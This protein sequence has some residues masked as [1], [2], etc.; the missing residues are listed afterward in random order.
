MD[1]HDNAV[2]RDDEADLGQGTGT[3]GSRDQ[4]EPVV[5]VKDMDG[6]AQNVEHVLV[7]DPVF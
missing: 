7:A 5:Q 4:R 3:V 1:D 6:V 2:H